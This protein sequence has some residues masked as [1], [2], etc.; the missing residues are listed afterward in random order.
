MKSMQVTSLGGS[1]AFALT[2]LLS[3]QLLGRPGAS[4]T[5]ALDAP[6]TVGIA[7]FRATWDTPVILDEEGTTE[8]KD[9][10]AGVK[11]ATAIWSLEKRRPG[12]RGA[13]AFDALHR[14]ALIR[15]PDAAEKIAAQLRKGHL[16][17][18]VELVLPYKDTELYPVGDSSYA[19]PDGYLYRINWGVGDDW[20]R[21]PP[22]WHAVGWGLRRPW[23][24]DEKTGPTWNAYINGAGYWAKHGAQDEIHDRHPRRFGPAEV[25]F[26]QPE[27]RLDVTASLTD[28]AFGKTLA[29]RLRGLADHGFLVKKWETYDHRYYRQVYEFATATGGRAILIRTPRLVVTFRPGKLSE[30]LDPL[31]PPTDVKALARKLRDTKAGGKPTAVMPDNK[32]LEELAARAGTKPEWM[33]QWQWQR[34][35]QL[36]GLSS[37]GEQ[38]LPFWYDFVDEG[39]RNTRLGRRFYDARERR[40][41]RYFTH[42]DV[43]AGWV[44][45]LIGRQPR[46]WY[47]FE[48]AREMLQWYAYQSAMPA[49][50]RDNFHAVWEAWLMPHK[51]TKDLVHPM[52]DQLAGRRVTAP[53]YID[54][55]YAKTGDWRGNKSFYRDGFCYVMSTQNFNTMA[56]VGALLG[57]AIIHSDYAL[58]DG[59]HGIEHFPLRLWAWGDGASQENIDH[60][61]FPVTLSAQKTVVDFGPT[62]FDR[63]LG[64]SM[65]A[66][67]M[68]EAISAYHPRLRRFTAGSSRTS[69]AHVLVTQDGLQHIMHTLA[70]EGA[71]HDLGT[72][73]ASGNLPILGHDVSP[74]QIAEQTRLGPWAPA[75][76]MN[77]PVPYEETSTR[78]GGWQHIYQGEHYGLASLSRHWPRIQA[79]AHWRRD[80]KVVDKLPEVV[81]MDVRYGVNLTRFVDSA[82]GFIEAF[83]QQGIFQHKN[84]MV[85]ATR[86]AAT[87][88]LK[89]VV[90]REG[91]RSL[92]SS[93]ILFNYQDSPSWEIYV[94]GK[95]VTRL[96]HKAKQG[97]CITIKDGVSYLGVIPMPATDLGRTNEVVLRAGDKQSYGNM[98]FEPAL[99]IDSYNL[100]RESPIQVGEGEYAKWPKSYGGFVVEIGDVKE[101]DG[102]PS[103]QQHM[104][105]ARLKTV[106]DQEKGK[107]EVRYTS[108]KDVLEGTFEA[109]LSIPQFSACRVN[110][111]DS[112][113]P[114]GI[115]RDTSLAQQGKTGVLTKNGATLITD[116]G[117]TAYLRTDP[118]TGTWMALNPTPTPTK[119]S[120][121]VPGHVTIAAE[122]RLGLARVVVCPKEGAVWIDYAVRNGEKNLVSNLQIGGL[123]KP[124]KVIRNG[125]AVPGKLASRVVNGKTIHFVP[126]P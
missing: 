76:M 60:Y 66:K 99:V 24:A 65:L 30:D 19:P 93:I 51:P 80:S 85:V 101:Y 36:A 96:P 18:K 62:R 117:V 34:I 45:T 28:V 100:Q 111:R 63:L 122:G 70:P 8:I 57:G 113:L 14:S 44:D 38:G 48:M 59:R 125:K 21:N 110:G 2:L 5:L 98:T 114:S 15:F 107:L 72:P 23:S 64:E 112:D 9:K 123:G 71:L 35:K 68:E 17:E 16:V 58:Q 3:T 6:Q 81:T 53:N 104:H 32:K 61:Y 121:T 29:S 118:S 86:P 46:G 84:K 4:V 26:K 106:W 13:L 77:K 41:K 25:S 97:Q 74:E 37:S 73:L 82:P 52:S 83:G 56:S 31:A 89:N 102:F 92:Q 42:E 1:L 120:L 105:A 95:R 119:W 20:K 75:W 55:Y 87:D 109:A 67:S 50:A 78:G 91:L 12:Q 7:G 126:L 10:S 79:L 43:F 54:S 49:P 94:D 22:R 108:G 115:Q 40:W 39:M 69:L 116:P 11:G 27:G 33:P 124:P 47:G 103:F 90:R 88:W